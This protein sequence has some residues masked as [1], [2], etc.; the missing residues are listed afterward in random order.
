MVKERAYALACIIEARWHH[1]SRCR[2]LKSGDKNTQYFHAVASARHRRNKVSILRTQTDTITDE[3]K[4]RDAFRIQMEGLLGV[5]NNVI[6]FKPTELYPTNPDL[7]N[8]QNSFSKMEIETAVKQ[9]AKNKASGPDGIPNELIQK[10]WPLFKDELTSIIHAFYDHSLNLAEVN[11][12]NIIMIPKKEISEN[13]GGYRPIS[14]MNVV[15]K[16][17]PKLL[18]NRLRTVLPDLISTNQMASIQ[19]RQITE[20]F[21]AT[22]EMLYHISIALS[23]LHFR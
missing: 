6:P 18:A 8:L 11:Q 15:P 9:L 23:H 13:V 21:N 2:W 1:R 7:S 4:I 14:V 12:A 19:G 5:E 3:I 16:L 22:R 17:I 10:H 20:N